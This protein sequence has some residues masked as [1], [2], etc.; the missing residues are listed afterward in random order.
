MAPLTKHALQKC[1]LFFQA[2]DLQAKDECN[3]ITVLHIMQ[4][5]SVADTRT[6]WEINAKGKEIGQ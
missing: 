1:V 4:Y 5:S 6:W 3:E 2:S